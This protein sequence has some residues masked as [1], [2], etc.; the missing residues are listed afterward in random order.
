MFLIQQSHP[1]IMNHSILTTD[2]CRVTNNYCEFTIVKIYTYI[3]IIIITSL[4]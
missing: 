1:V 4:I 2:R 3:Y